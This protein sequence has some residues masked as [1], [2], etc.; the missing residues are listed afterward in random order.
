MPS[1][2]KFSR[3]VC[4]PLDNT[5]VPSG[6]YK[7]SGSS[8]D[9]FHSLSISDSICSS[10]Q[11]Q[12]VVP[13][14]YCFHVSNVCLIRHL[15]LFLSENCFLYYR[16]LPRCYFPESLPGYPEPGSGIPS[17]LGK[18]VLPHPVASATLNCNCL[19]F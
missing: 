17:E 5:Q 2:L 15:S 6:D 7:D 11:R 12:T 8:P 14:T 19:V 1:F 16:C 3:A 13:L 18:C 4:V 10:S 9:G